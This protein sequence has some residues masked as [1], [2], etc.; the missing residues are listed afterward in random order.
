MHGA[1]FVQK[2]YQDILGFWT[3]VGKIFKKTQ[4]NHLKSPHMVG[5]CAEKAAK[6][7]LNRQKTVTFQQNP[8]IS[9]FCRVMRET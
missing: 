2:K 7:Q 3:F 9:P 1:P 4:K 6:K 8:A 5:Y